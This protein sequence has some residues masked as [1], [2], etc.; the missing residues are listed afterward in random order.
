MLGEMISALHARDIDVVV[1][2]CLVYADWY[3]DMHPETA[4]LGLSP[5]ARY[6]AIQ[7]RKNEILL[8]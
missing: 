8:P 5:K 1:Y 2:C 3:G 7:Q 4:F 6:G